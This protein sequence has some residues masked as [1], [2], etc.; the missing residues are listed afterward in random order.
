MDTTRF[1]GLMTGIILYIIFVLVINIWGYAILPNDC[2]MKS[3]NIKIY[4]I[5]IFIS[6]T[7][8]VFMS[9][10]IHC[11]INCG[12]TQNRDIRKNMLRGTL[13]IFSILQIVFVIQRINTN[14]ECKGLYY[15]NFI[16][17]LK[18]TMY[19][20]FAILAL[21]LISFFGPSFWEKIKENREE[22]KKEKGEEKKKRS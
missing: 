20:S 17:W 12:D 1:K 14:N 15:H 3:T 5:S 11:E 13:F 18:I 7:M 19:V 4:R 6:V 21:I 16:I 2:N 8:L 10:Y 22:E 9:V